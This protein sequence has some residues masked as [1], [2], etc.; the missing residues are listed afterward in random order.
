M[1][2]ASHPEFYRL[3]SSGE[4]AVGFL[5]ELPSETVQRDLAAVRW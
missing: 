3:H 2:L 5:E 1:K 4:Q